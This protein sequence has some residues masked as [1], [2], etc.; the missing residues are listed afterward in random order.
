MLRDPEKTKNEIIAWI[1]KY[2]EEN[3]PSCIYPAA[4]IPVSQRP[5]APRHWAKTGSSAF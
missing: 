1:Q 5:F 3:G 4:R 2:F